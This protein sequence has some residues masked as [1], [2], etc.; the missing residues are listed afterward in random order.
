MTVIH[1]VH[2]IQCKMSADPTAGA[3]DAEIPET[4]IPTWAEYWHASVRAHVRHREF[5]EHR[6]YINQ[7][8]KDM[9]DE[10]WVSD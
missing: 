6:V 10:N 7:S 8:L 3:I 4:S 1:I 5:P 9:L 2:G